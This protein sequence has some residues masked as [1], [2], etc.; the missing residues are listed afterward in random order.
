MHGT[1]GKYKNTTEY[2]TS[3]GA[4]LMERGK[5]SCTVAVFIW[6]ILAIEIDGSYSHVYKAI[7]VWNGSSY[8]RI[9]RMHIIFYQLRVV[10]S[11][12]TILFGCI[13]EAYNPRRVEEREE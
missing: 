2:D 13:K 12:H 1:F 4:I 10:V 11:P 5:A 9:V 6:L 8:Y 7:K 3:T